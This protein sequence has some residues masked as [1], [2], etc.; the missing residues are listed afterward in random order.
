[1]Q[2]AYCITFGSSEVHFILMF[3]K[4]VSVCVFT[5]SVISIHICTVSV[6]TVVYY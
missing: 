1:M 3:K 6:I 2:S 5:V 4:Q